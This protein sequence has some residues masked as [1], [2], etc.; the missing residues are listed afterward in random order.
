MWEGS[1]L[2]I[3]FHL[4]LHLGGKFKNEEEER[5]RGCE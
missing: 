5:R 2:L 3:E 1:L 4:L